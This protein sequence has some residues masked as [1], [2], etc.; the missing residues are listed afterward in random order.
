MGRHRVLIVVV[1]CAALLV[2][3][4][5]LAA[6]SD[7]A[8]GGSL[9]PERA[10]NAA[11]VPAPAA[12][13]GPAP[14][15]LREELVQAPRTPEPAQLH[16]Q[17]IDD[18]PEEEIEEAPEDPLQTG[19]CALRLTIVD[20]ASAAPVRSLVHLWRLDAPENE[21]YG[22]GDQLQRTVFVPA[23]GLLLE[24][25]PAD[26]YRV[27]AQSQARREPAPP[28]FEVV[29]PLTHHEL[30]I[31][32]PIPHEGWLEVY[33]PDGR[34]LEAADL[35]PVRLRSRWSSN[36]S[37]TWV[38]RRE[39][40]LEGVFEDVEIMDSSESSEEEAERPLTQVEVGGFR[41]SGLREGNHGAGH[42]CVCEARFPGRSWVLVRLDPEQV[43]F[44]DP[45]NL[46]LVAVSAPLS[47]LLPHVLLPDGRDGNSFA[48]SVKA[49]CVAQPASTLDPAMPWAELEVDVRVR[50]QGHEPLHFRWRPTGGPPQD[51]VLVPL[52]R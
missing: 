1:A 19:A 48:E 20:R 17:S 28:A 45:K 5:R 12:E 37:A 23:E 31:G 52:P 10:S 26:E 46:R 44:S 35:S 49:S 6:P 27:V 22:P 38:R 41:L 11:T 51:R 3:G 16:A 4:W 7:D 42:T 13:L 39:C 36:E 40:K 14:A 8:Q 30:T 2:L 21:F 50:V 32:L 29:G 9:G 33:T 47:D 34:R 24:D 43:D 18:P 15:P 25:L